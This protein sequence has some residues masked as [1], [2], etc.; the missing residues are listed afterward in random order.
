[1]MTQTETNNLNT[2]PG[3]IEIGTYESPD[4]LDDL[5]ILNTPQ[6]IGSVHGLSESSLVEAAKRGHSMAFNMLSEP[7]RQQLFCVARRITGSI[8]DAEDAV[9]DTLLSAF[10]HMGDFDSRSSFKTWL[11]SIAINSAL[12][13]LRKKRTSREI[14]TDYNDDSGA[15]GLRNKITDRQPNPEMRYAQS[16]EETILEKAIES[17]RPS[18]RVVV[19]IQQLQEQS[20]QETAEAIGISLG[21]AKSRLFHARAALRRSLIPKLMRQPRYTE[22]RDE[23]GACAGEADSHH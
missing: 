21:A 18:L 17:L 22:G 23:Y 14:A 7:Y 16:E 4:S 11:T 20:M 15:D 12:M 3:K 1:M 8:E 6:P 2:V 9:Q 13:N 5:R 19:E 10:L